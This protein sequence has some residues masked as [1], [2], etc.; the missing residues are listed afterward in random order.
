MRK[1]LT[2][3]TKGRSVISLFGNVVAWLTKSVEVLTDVRLN[4]LNLP[5][6]QLITHYNCAPLILFF[7]LKLNF[8]L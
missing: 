1:R 6:M 5:I 3:I 2:Q 4:L 7:Y 8:L